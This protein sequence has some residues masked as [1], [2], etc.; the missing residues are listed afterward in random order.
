MQNLS[1]TVTIYYEFAM[2]NILINFILPVFTAL[3]AWLGTAYRNKQKKEKD[4]LDNV[5]QI[6]DIQKEFI[7]KQE[8]TIKQTTQ[9]LAVVDKRQAHKAAAVRKA[10]NCTIPSESCPVLQYDAMGADSE[11]IGN[12]DKCKHN[13]S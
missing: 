9:R 3:I 5:K 8:E 11:C 13:V 7:S 1:F 2:E 12:C 10:Y 6:I 4:I